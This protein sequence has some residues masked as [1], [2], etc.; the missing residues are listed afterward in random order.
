[1]P[2]VKPGLGQSISGLL[3]VAAG[4]IVFV[5]AAVGDASSNSF[6]PRWL[7][8]LFGLPFL[9]VGLWVLQIQRLWAGR[10]P[11][12]KVDGE[13]IFG[14][15]IFVIMGLILVIVSFVD[16]DEHFNA[17]RWVVTAAGGTFVLAGVTVL[18]SGWRKGRTSAD[19]MAGNLLMLLVIT[20]FALVPLGIVLDPQGQVDSSARLC[21]TPAAIML[22]GIA[23]VGWYRVF[24]QLQQTGWQRIT[25]L[26]SPKLLIAALV[27]LVIV[28]AALM[29]ASSIRQLSSGAQPTATAPARF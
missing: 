27:L 26:R 10:L 24:K 22:G 28:V 21:F 6:Q 12:L 2:N 16:E 9:L 11:R 17:P 5:L 7:M 3:F 25:A 20:F 29:L 13:T 8:A 4:V 23:G 14:G 18:W 19:S 15:L 1:M